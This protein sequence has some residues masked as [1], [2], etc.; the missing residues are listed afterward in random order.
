MCQK[1]KIPCFAVKF[2]FLT[3]SY[4]YIDQKIGNFLM[5]RYR[6][7]WFSVLLYSLLIR[8]GQKHIWLK[9][10]MK[11]I[12][13]PPNLYIIYVVVLPRLSKKILGVWDPTPYMGPRTPAQAVLGVMGGPGTHRGWA[14]KPQIFLG[15]SGKSHYIYY[16]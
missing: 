12:D 3:L 10:I 8:F 1:F 11:G 13:Q 6:P 4:L 2:P 14:P 16:I 5:F 9:K 7:K 15:K